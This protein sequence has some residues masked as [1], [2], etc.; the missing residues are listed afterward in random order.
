MKSLPKQGAIP[1]RV[2]LGRRFSSSVVVAGAFAKELLEENKFLKH[3]ITIRT[4]VIYCLCN[5]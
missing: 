1:N 4:H 3:E 2:G 5:N